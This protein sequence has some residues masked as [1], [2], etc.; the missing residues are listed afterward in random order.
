MV[1]KS[2]ASWPKSRLRIPQNS[3]TLTRQPTR[4]V[5]DKLQDKNAFCP[6]RL[7]PSTTCTTPAACGTSSGIEFLVAPL[8]VKNT[9][10]CRHGQCPKAVKSRGSAQAGDKACAEESTDFA[11]GKRHHQGIECLG[12]G[13]ALQVI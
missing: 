1:H 8:A 11:T 2:K 5:L 13:L 9:S 3:E 7:S 10:G 6:R 4:R 12:L